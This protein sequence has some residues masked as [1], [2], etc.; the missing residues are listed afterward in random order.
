MS[1]MRFPA[2]AAAGVL[3]LC[4]APAWP[5]TPEQAEAGRADYSQHCASCHGADFRLLPTARLA[6]PEFVNRWRGRS[7][8]EM[9]AQLRATMPPEG[10]GALP[11][12][13]YLNVIAYLLEQNG[14]SA[15]ADPLA[16]SSTLIGALLPSAGPPGLGGAEPEPEPTGV[17]VAGSV[18]DFEPLTEQ[19]LLDPRPGDWPMLRRDY[20]ASSFSPLD[21][22]TPENAHRLQLAWI[23]PMRDGGTNQPSPLAYRGTIFLNNTGGIIQALDGRDGSLIWEHRLEDN[24]AMRGMALYRD[25]LYLQSAGRL[26]ALDARTGETVWNAAMPDGRASSSGPLVAN[27][28]VIQGMGGCSRYEEQKCFISGYDADTGEQLWRF[29]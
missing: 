19:Q 8:N 17:I 22:V 12:E 25:K 7:T 2:P 28:V 11:E 21:E 14:A 5:I 23:W 4:A 26:V 20:A 13:A 10:P 3:A 29:S 9:L 27:G 16:A 18:P 24:V 15:A 6:G 1:S